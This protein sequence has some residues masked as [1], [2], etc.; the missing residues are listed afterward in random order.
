MDKPSNEKPSSDIATEP[1][2]SD[3]KRSADERKLE[4][5]VAVWN[6]SQSV[7]S[8]SAHPSDPKRDHESDLSS[9]IVLAQVNRKHLKKPAEDPKNKGSN[10]ST[11]D[12]SNTA[13]SSD[14]RVQIQLP[15]HQQEEAF[16]NEEAVTNED[17]SNNNGGEA[18][19]AGAQ[20]EAHSDTADRQEST[21]AEDQNNQDAAAPLRYDV[22]AVVSEYSSSARTG[23][24]GASNNNMMSTSGSGSG[25]NTGSGTGSGTAS[26]SNQ[27]GS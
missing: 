7:A 11:N 15:Q 20:V 3:L 22:P 23:S 2:D 19:Q 8:S 21:S 26:R 14:K 6:T 17:D 1:S 4:V 10:N 18:E 16:Q 5:P 13:S 27:G 24:S 12:G 25:G 9:M